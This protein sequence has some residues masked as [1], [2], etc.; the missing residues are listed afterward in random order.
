MDQFHYIR[1]NTQNTNPL[2]ELK[3]LRNPTPNNQMRIWRKYSIDDPYVENFGNSNSY[4]SENKQERTQR[5]SFWNELLPKIS[6][7]RNNL[8]NNIPRELQ[9]SPD[10]AAGFRHAMYTL[11][12]L[13]VALLA[14]LLVCIVLLKRRSKERESHLHMGY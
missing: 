7:I 14:L 5:V 11:V 8:S 1:V 13:V 4:T 3:N 10:P 6:N 12:A 2:F 9:N